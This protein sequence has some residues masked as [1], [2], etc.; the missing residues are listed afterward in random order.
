MDQVRGLPLLPCHSV[1]SN[2]FGLSCK[3]CATVCRYLRPPKRKV[4]KV[5]K[6]R[7]ALS[8]IYDMWHKKIIADAAEDRARV[9]E[10]HTH[11]WRCCTH[12]TGR[13]C[14]PVWSP[15]LLNGI[16]MA[17]HETHRMTLL[18]RLRGKFRL[19][20]STLASL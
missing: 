18:R 11:V 16:W 17:C 7:N 14:V 19:L 15:T 1:L 10:T 6:L 12:P 3:H 13:S 5:L 9:S 2:R 8:L 20:A 4:V